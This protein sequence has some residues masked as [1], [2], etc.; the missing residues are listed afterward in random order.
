MALLKKV[1]GLG[2]YI[3]RHN[4]EFDDAYGEN[5]SA[6]KYHYGMSDNEKIQAWADDVKKISGLDSTIVKGMDV[7]MIR[8]KYARAIVFDK[9]KGVDYI[10]DR[11]KD[12]VGKMYAKWSGR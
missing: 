2:G 1:A 4:D 6:V 10:N 5:P 3:K 9:N 11:Y 7:P 8:A 12:E